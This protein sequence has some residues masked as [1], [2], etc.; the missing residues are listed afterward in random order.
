MELIFA[1]FIVANIRFV[2]IRVSYNT[3]FLVLMLYGA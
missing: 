3:Y 2:S 1:V